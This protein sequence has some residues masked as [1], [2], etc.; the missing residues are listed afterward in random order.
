MGDPPPTEF[1]TRSMLSLPRREPTEL[2]IGSAFKR[3]AAI[4]EESI[5][6]VLPVSDGIPR[7]RLVRNSPVGV[8]IRLEKGNAGGL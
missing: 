7:T 3:D 6:P 1:D 4:Q 2:Q 8:Q 5:L